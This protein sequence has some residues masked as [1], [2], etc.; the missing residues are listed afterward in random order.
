MTCAS[1]GVQLR[2]PEPRTDPEAELTIILG[3]AGSVIAQAQSME[4]IFGCCIGLDMTLRGK[5]RQSSRKPIDTYPMP[6]H[7]IMMR[8]I[9][10]ADLPS[11]I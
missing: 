2:F 8:S 6:G 4:H 1:E 9:S 7:W 5:E 3:K 10:L 11:T